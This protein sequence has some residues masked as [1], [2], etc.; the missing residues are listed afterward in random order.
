M[1]SSSFSLNAFWYTFKYLPLIKL[2]LCTKHC[3]RV[4]LMSFSQSSQHLCEGCAGRDKDV[5]TEKARKHSSRIPAGNRQSRLRTSRLTRAP[6]PG[7]SPYMAALSCAYLS[8]GTVCQAQMRPWG[9]EK[10]RD[11]LRIPGMGNGG[12]ETWIQ[13]R[14]VPGPW[15]FSGPLCCFLVFITEKRKRERKE[16]RMGGKGEREREVRT[17]F[18][19]LLCSCIYP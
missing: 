8:C 13:A 3:L 12:A 19:I 4:V 16:G 10:P 5:G 1:L 9:S 2:L 15:P 6:A 17:N 14:W 11:M 18:W 7:Q